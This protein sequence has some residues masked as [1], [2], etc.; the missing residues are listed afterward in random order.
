MFA[1]FQFEGDNIITIRLL[2]SDADKWEAS[3]EMLSSCSKD[4][5]IFQLKLYFP[6]YLICVLL[7][8][9]HSLLEQVQKCSII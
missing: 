4:G 1:G 7:L 9:Q 8:L 6:E 2:V 5:N 3:E